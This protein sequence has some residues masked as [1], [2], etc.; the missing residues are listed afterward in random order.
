MNERIPLEKFEDSKT[1]IFFHVF[2]FPTLLLEDIL[3][4]VGNFS[5][6]FCNKLG[7]KYVFTTC[8]IYSSILVEPRIW[9]ITDYRNDSMYLIEGKE[10]AILFDTGM[11]TGNLKGYIQDLTDKSIEVIISH[12]H[13]DHIMQVNQFKR[14]YMNHKEFEIIKIFNM[15]ID[16][17]HFLNIKDKDIFDLGDTRL[18]VM[19]VPGHTPGS[20]V[21]LDEENK[22]IF[23]G[24][25]VGAGYTWMHLPGC[26]PLSRY[27]ESLY[28][29]YERIKN[30]KKIY[31]GH[32]KESKPLD[33][34]YLEDLIKAVEKVIRR[35]VIGKTY[36]YG[37]FEGLYV[38]FGSVVL[39]YN[40]ANI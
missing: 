19:E 23:S 17:T 6:L 34:F 40:P 37:N 33:I 1:L 39:V 22:I 30:F 26:L 4:K 2:Q 8:H 10:K 32:L 28:K 27:I 12:A 13:W 16:Y 7:G 14:V 24:D 31:H 36:N 38:E 3:K 9:H 5:S 15:D 29:L 35:E 20:I 11:G 25:A 18:E 21:L